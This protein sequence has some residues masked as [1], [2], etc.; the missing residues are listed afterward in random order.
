MTYVSQTIADGTKFKAGEQFTLS[1]VVKNIGT[2]TWNS[3]YRVRF[4]GG[5]RFGVEDFQIGKTVAP[6]AALTITVHMTAP[7]KVGQYNSIW[8]LTNNDGSNFG[9]FTFSLEVK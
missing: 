2:T 4:F 7:D 1:W 8:V 9:S 6:N 3:T 5:T